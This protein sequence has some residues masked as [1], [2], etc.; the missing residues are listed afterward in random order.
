YRPSPRSRHQR[1]GSQRRIVLVP[2]RIALADHFHKMRALCQAGQRDGSVDC[3]LLA[4]W[5]GVQAPLVVSVTGP[6]RP[7]SSRNAAAFAIDAHNE[8]GGVLI[9]GSARFAGNG[10]PERNNSPHIATIRPDP[11]SGRSRLEPEPFAE[12]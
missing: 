3:C 8:R 10:C 6:V 9:G 1:V 4:P 11:N 12:D 2:S 5:S 7:T